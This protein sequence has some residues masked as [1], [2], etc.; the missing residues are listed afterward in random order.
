[1]F[2][3]GRGHDS[4]VIHELDRAFC[5]LE[6]GKLE[7]DALKRLIFA[8]LITAAIGLHTASAADPVGEMHLTA[9]EPTAALRDAQHHNV[10]RITVWYPATA[11]SAESAVTLGPPAQPLRDVGRD[12]PNALFAAGDARRPVI[13]LSH[14]FGG[15]ARIMGWLGIPLA[16]AGYV[17]IAV[18]HPGNNAIDPITVAG[19]I[20]WWDRAVDLHTALDAARRDRVIGPHLNTDDVGLAGFSAGGFTALVAAGARVDRAHFFQFCATHPEDG[21]CRPQR[22]LPLSQ[23]ENAAA[24]R[25]PAVAADIAHAGDDYAI[26]GV[27]AVFAMAPVL[28][29]ALDPDSL[30]HIAVP[31]SIVLGD[32]DTVAPPATNALAAAA[33][34]PSARLTQSP[35]VGHYDFLADCTAA[36]RKI[37]PICQTAVPQQATHAVAIDA[38]LSLF[39]ATLGKP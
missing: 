4:A 9:T 18:D 33:L 23:E 34:I 13:L 35:G 30:R 7:T 1:M 22:E 16:R 6:R 38:A 27:R 32:V 21:V 36:G 5:W 10:L 24:E 26:P 8:A 11:D 3:Y 37:V 31:V 19:A 25:E 28:V 39:A 2:G 29:Q 12:A 14:G 20:L 17:V 15:T